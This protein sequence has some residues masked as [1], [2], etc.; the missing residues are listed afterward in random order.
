MTVHPTA[1]PRAQRTRARLQD[2]L[3]DLVAEHDLDQ[4][5]VSDVTKRAGV[6]RS[7][8]Y[9][10]F[11][12]THDLAAHACTA[13]FDGIIAAAPVVG[14]G[15]P[16]EVLGIGG[17][18]LADLF[19]RIGERADLYRALL[20]PTGSARVIDHLRRRLTIAIH[21]NFTH[22][23]AASHADDPADIPDDP[24]AALLAGTLLSAATDW[25]HR[26]HPET[27]AELSARIAPALAALLADHPSLIEMG[28]VPPAPSDG[29][30]P[31]DAQGTSAPEA[32][33]APGVPEAPRTRG[34][35]A[36]PRGA[37]LHD[38]LLDAALRL[39]VARGYRG[40]S[41]QDIASEVGCAKAS[42]LYHFSDKQAILRELLT[43][44]VTEFLALGA[45][46]T[47]FPDDQVAEATVRGFADITLRHRR[48]V[49][50]LLSDVAETTGALDVDDGL[51]LGELLITSLSGRSADPQIRMRA[52]M[53]L[54]TILLGS[55]GSTHLALP[56]ADAHAALVHGALR[57][58]TP[59]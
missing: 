46:L 53:A 43:P 14:P 13:L 25:L 3:L 45:R 10:H 56:P 58:L 39:F 57:A 35:G 30:E 31:G 48:Q 47:L 54:G 33:T 29:P 38:K 37:A 9:E 18:A 12:D 59:D 5:S 22:P 21:V 6:N 24:T 36:H 42:V 23:T 7:T 16:P 40:T 44:A 49:G 17:D 34:S 52:W 11:T 1:N 20:G 28:L 32:G 15:S 50:L 55:A 51:D 2:A 8:F 26:A 27:P 19:A 4:I 41:L